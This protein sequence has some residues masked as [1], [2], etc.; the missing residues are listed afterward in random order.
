MKDFEG[1]T[2]EEEYNLRGSSQ[3]L[4]LHIPI[5]MGQELR[6]YHQHITGAVVSLE[7]STWFPTRRRRV[8]TEHSLESMRY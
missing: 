6:V 4:T 3:L 7:I 1:T 5:N 8:D 2:I